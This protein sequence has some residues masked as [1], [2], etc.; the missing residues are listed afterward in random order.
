MPENWSGHKYMSCH[1]WLIT[2]FFDGMIG[3]AL[4]AEAGSEND[5][6]L[7]NHSD[8]GGVL[9]EAQLGQPQIYTTGT[10]KGMHADQC[11]ITFRTQLHNNLK[12]AHFLPF[13]C[14]TNGTWGDLRGSLNAWIIIRC[15]LRRCKLSA[16]C[17]VCV[18]CLQMLSLSLTETL[19][20]STLV[21][22]LRSNL[23]TILSKCSVYIA[24]RCTNTIVIQSIKML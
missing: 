8:L 24:V 23:P 15:C 9:L 20:P 21:S 2:S 7:Q 5:H 4:G 10:D 13:A 17:S 22:E 19:L 3:L 6:A 14:R 11:T 1:S 16:L 12:T 18:A